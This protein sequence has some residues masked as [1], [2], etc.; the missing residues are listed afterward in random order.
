MTY[1]ITR[2]S[3]DDPNRCQSN[4]SR[5]QCVNLAVEDSQYCVVHGGRKQ[6]GKALYEFSK[7][8]YQ[9]R[10]KELKNHSES[11]SLRVEI[12]ILRMMLETKINSMTDDVELMLGQQSI[13]DLVVKI[14][15]L[16]SNCHKI[17]THLSNILTVEQATQMIS[18][19]SD[20]IDANITDMDIKTLIANLIDE[21]LIKVLE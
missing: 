8:K 12:G 14:N 17:E 21:T 1:E 4:D 19:I 10:I 9:N 2:A 13:A 16:V 18:E 7:V 20:I 11:K 3:E 15:T 6:K 5:G